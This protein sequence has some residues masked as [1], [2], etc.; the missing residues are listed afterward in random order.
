MKSGRSGFKPKP[1]QAA[2]QTWGALILALQSGRKQAIAWL[3]QQ[4]N[5]YTQD[6]EN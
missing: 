6:I 1:H 2:V 4:S 3:Y 5:T